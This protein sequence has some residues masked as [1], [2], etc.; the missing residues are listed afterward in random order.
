[1]WKTVSVEFKMK[2][3]LNKNRLV[4]GKI[5]CVQ[6]LNRGMSSNSWRLTS[7]NPVKSSEELMWYTKNVLLKMF[8]NSLNIGLLLGAWVDKAVH[9]V[10]IDGHFVIRT[11]LDAAANKEDNTGHL[12]KHERTHRDWY[13]WKRCNSKQCYLFDPYLSFTVI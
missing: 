1:M 5:R 2:F 8:I 4:A 13:P 10:E 6:G 11:V 12:L 3:E 7:R 9:E